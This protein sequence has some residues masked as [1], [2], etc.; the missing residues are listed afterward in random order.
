DPAFIEER[1]K[2]LSAL[3]ITHAH[4]DHIGAVS[5]L[6]PRLRCPIYCSA[7]TAAVLE[8]KFNENPECRDAEI[9][10]VGPGETIKAGP[11]AVTFVPVSH[12]VPETRSLFIETAAGRVVH[13]GDWNLDPAPTLGDPT[14]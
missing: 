3:I 13:T 12:S 14:D 4:E 9:T 6:W 1:R 8:E 2:N 5:H 11:F 7:F 10:V